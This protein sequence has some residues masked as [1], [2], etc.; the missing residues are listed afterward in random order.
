M[1]RQWLQFEGHWM[2]KE[3]AALLI[4]ALKKKIADNKAENTKLSR[5]LKA[6]QSFKKRFD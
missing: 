6:A 3:N 2:T 1:P 5:R 4:S